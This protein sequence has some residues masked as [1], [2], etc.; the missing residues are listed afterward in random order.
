MKTPN[1]PFAR[2][3]FISISYLLFFLPVS[4]Q[5]TFQ[6]TYGGTVMDLGIGTQ[7]TTD[8]GYIITGY[9]NSFNAGNYAIYLIKT[10][11]NGDTL[12]TKTFGGVS[13]D[14]GYS[15]QQTIDGGYALTGMTGSFDVGGG[16][17]YLLKTDAGGN[18][19]WTKT[20]GG[21]GSDEGHA[22]HQTLDGGYIIIGSTRSFGAGSSDVYLIKTNG[23]GDTLWTKTYGGADNEYGNSVQ[24]TADEGYIIMASTLSFGTG[25]SDFYLIKTDADGDTLWSKTFG[26]TA[27]DFGISIQQTMD[28]GYILVGS[29]YSFGMG[30]SDVYLIKT[31]STGNTLWTKTFGG[32]NYDYGISVHQTIGGEFIVA[33]STFN[34]GGG[35]YLIKTDANGDSLWTK[36]LGIGSGLEGNSIQQTADGGFII[37]GDLPSGGPANVYLI[38]TDSLG[39]SGC[40]QSNTT[41]IVTT[42]ATQVTSPI[43]IVTS[44]STIV[45][46]PT[47]PVGS[48][49]TVT[50]ICISVGIN[51]ITKD[52][53][54][55]ISPNPFTS[56]ISIAVQKQNTTQATILIKNILGQMVFE[57]EMKTP[58][59]EI[60]IGLSF[61]ERGIYLVEVV[62]DGSP[63]SYREVRKIVK[64]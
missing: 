35:V 60:K 15:V 24:Q 23:S 41:T 51:E 9:T 22:V 3:L 39:N 18:S 54:F 33:G 16:D 64:E 40:N 29:T 62:A 53:L 4:A 20:F 19:L 30:L 26:G 55:S 57:K 58:K 11:A 63:D 32:T 10:S 5:I 38:K 28:G 13:N 17:I 42:P 45:T 59:Q 34:F 2:L 21:T 56:E 8:G 37:T 44:P 36:T 46:S 14:Y 50:T 27:N 49:A 7:Q 61:L 52:N 47:P 1:F 48:G 43:T 31:D 6:K 12:W 25:N